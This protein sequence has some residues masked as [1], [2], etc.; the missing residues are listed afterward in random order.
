MPL[1]RTEA[2]PTAPCY[3]GISASPPRSPGQESST[4]ILKE[5]DGQNSAMCQNLPCSPSRS[6]Q[7]NRATWPK[8]SLSY[9]WA[10]LYPLD[11]FPST[12]RAGAKLGS[13]GEMERRQLL[14]TLLHPKAATVAS[15]EGKDHE[16][17]VTFSKQRGARGQMTTSEEEG[18]P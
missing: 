5:P 10:A 17:P 7:L 8:G 3:T 4:L 9:S 12:S 16:R 13:A 2:Q 15:L 11:A 18:Q 14:R 1:P 6:C